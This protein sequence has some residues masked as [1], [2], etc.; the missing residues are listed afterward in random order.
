[1]NFE[2]GQIIEAEFT[3]NSQSDTASTNA[4]VNPQKRY[5]VLPD[6][7][8]DRPEKRRKEDNNNTN[9]NNNSDES[10][11]EVSQED[12]INDNQRKGKKFLDFSFDEEDSD[13]DDSMFSLEHTGKG[14]KKGKRRDINLIQ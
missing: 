5:H 14:R 2:N 10:T 4:I 7:I 13:E 1:V 11:A 12:S 6:L 3:S 8:S 9:N